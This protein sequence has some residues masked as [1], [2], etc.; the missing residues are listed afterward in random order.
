MYPIFRMTQKQIEALRKYKS[1]LEI[2]RNVAWHEGQI[3]SSEIFREVLAGAGFEKGNDL[4]L[5]ELREL[6][7]QLRE[8][9]GSTALAV[10]GS[11]SMFEANDLKVFNERMRDLLYSEGNLPDRVDAFIDLKYVG[12]QTV[13]QFLRKFDYEKYPFVAYFMLD[14]FEALSITE[15][16][17]E[18]ARQQSI[19]E[20][21]LE[22][23][24][25]HRRTYE[26]FQFF[27]VLREIKDTIK[28]KDYLEVQN[29]LWRISE[30]LS[31]GEKIDLRPP[32]PP[33]RKHAILMSANIE[34]NP[35]VFR[36]HQEHIR[37]VEAT[38]WGV[39]FPV[40]P[41]RFALPINGY[42]YATDTRKVTHVAKIEE[43]EAYD[44]PQMPKEMRLRPP[45][46]K[47]AHRTYFRF[48]KLESLPIPMEIHD[49]TQWNGKRVVR[50]PQNY[51]LIMDPTPP[52]LVVLTEIDRRII[53][54]LVTGRNIIFY[55]PPGTGKTRNAVKIARLFCGEGVKK[56]SF[57]TAN[58]EWT[59]YDVVGGPTFSGRTALKIKP[60][61]LTFA[62]KKCTDSV[63]ALG[64]P[65]WLIIDEINR[66][67]LDLAFGKIFSL[68]DVE[69]RGQPIFDESELA[70]MENADEYRRVTIPPDFRVLATMNTYDT[71]LLF[72]LGYAFRRRF[73]FV[74]I[75]SPFLQEPAQDVHEL[76]EQEWRRLELSS[77]SHLEEIMNEIDEWVARRA[78][79]RLSRRLK[80]SLAIAEDFDLQES[81]MTLNREIK[82]GDFDPFNP[83]RLACKLSEEITQREIV[84]A[85]YAQA[86]DVIK[87]ALVYAA[88]F[89][90]G[91]RRETM[92]KALD[93][94]VKAYF[95]PHVEY[96]LPR[97]RR[98]MTIGEKGEEEEAL[99]KLT[100]FEGFVER[101]GLSRSKRKMQEIISRLEMGETRI[102]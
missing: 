73:A 13:G 58:A 5:G 91:E 12:L 20:F 28:L 79:L 57:E 102:F 71:A 17:L 50:P 100:D 92:V 43:I 82:A 63:E 77:E 74:E 46:Y 95:V 97:A 25:Y 42:F 88:L 19:A 83:L 78:Y 4:S 52:R 59:T 93:E 31:A 64:L 68:L 94:A 1:E 39:D 72:S 101:L 16:Q 55:G 35:G 84:E 70:G 8:G 56:F 61:F 2:E 41:T 23:E 75:P 66:A 54:H 7:E 29:L 65:Y 22:S 44:S 27:V 85:G 81:L 40:D 99:K 33:E 36:Y 18:E 90:D 21:G 76:N 89:H 51:V 14:V 80:K 96:Y 86:V 37:R 48:S 62:A 49:F 24:G 26:Y 15:N 30:R 60:G 69:Y 45:E 10:K 67:N 11:T 53:A 38:Y 32:S 87:Y 98:K 6:G 9:L 47:E 34:R 3:V